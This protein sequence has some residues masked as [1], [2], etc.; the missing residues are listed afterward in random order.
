MHFKLW[1]TIYWPVSFPYTIYSQYLILE[2]AHHLFVQITVHNSLVFFNP[3]FH[4]FL[5]VEIPPLKG[6]QFK[7]HFFLSPLTTDNVDHLCVTAVL[8]VAGCS[9]CVHFWTLCSPL[10]PPW[11]QNT[12]FFCVYSKSTLCRIHCLS[13]EF[14]YASQSS[15]ITSNYAACHCT[16]R[17]R[18][19]LWSKN[20][21]FLLLSFP[22]YLRCGIFL[23]GC[24]FPVCK[25]AC[26]WSDGQMWHFFSINCMTLAILCRTVLWHPNISYV[27]LVSKCCRRNKFKLLP[28]KKEGIFKSLFL[29]F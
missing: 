8:E 4:Y 21:S 26:V 17:C 29:L 22:F 20:E 23:I 24:V 15:R 11:F 3:C 13:A 12:V 16:H 7:W 2:F 1:T 18:V 6:I 28:C 14:L 25:R 27:F 10:I 19:I 5:W 9:E